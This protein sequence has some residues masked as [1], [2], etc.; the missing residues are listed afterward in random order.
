MV[1]HVSTPFNTGVLAHRWKRCVRGFGKW[2]VTDRGRGSNL[3]WRC[4]VGNRQHNAP[5]VCPPFEASSLATFRPSRTFLSCRSKMFK[6][7]EV[8][9]A[10]SGEVSNTCSEAREPHVVS[11]SQHGWTRMAWRGMAT[12]RGFVASACLEDPGR[13]MVMAGIAPRILGKRGCFVADHG[14]RF[15]GTGGPT[16]ARACSCTTTKN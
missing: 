2:M 1:A 15:H 16:G 13:C 5:C 9:S 3:R 12:C 10:N 7:H 6:H 14:G 8:K 11:R 4:F